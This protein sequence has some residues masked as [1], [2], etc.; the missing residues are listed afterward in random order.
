MR[1][2]ADRIRGMFSSIAPTYD[3]LNHALS[4]GI[5]LWW[6]RETV[7][8][9]LGALGGPQPGETIHALDIAT[10][11]GDLARALARALG[12]RGRVTGVDFAA[13]M[14]RL[15]REKERRLVRNRGGAAARPPVLY[16]EADALRLPFAANR[17]DLVT[18]AFGLRNLEDPERG[19][20]EMIRVT[21]PGGWVAVLEF[22]RPEG[23]FF[24]AVYDFYFRRILPRVGGWVSGSSAYQYLTD[25]V[26]EFWSARE[27]RRR[28]RAAGLAPVRGWHFSR[29]VAALS[30]G[31]KPRSPERN[32][33]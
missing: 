2:N 23:L 9:A 8:L 1:K 22:A 32:S 7:R 16:A 24:G 33:E 11:T 31:Q 18:S 12:G 19:L 14:L 21:R 3:F 29:G 25:S 10:G 6:R 28:M 30:L 4:L 27:L 20:R 13:P 15:A 26:L 17:F 5:D